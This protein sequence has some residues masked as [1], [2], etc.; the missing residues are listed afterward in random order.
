MG[1]QFFNMHASKIIFS[2][3]AAYVAAQED[4][5]SPDSPTDTA[6]TAVASSS[7]LATRLSYVTYTTTNVGT[8]SPAAS[9]PA[10]SL[11][12]C[13]HPCP[14]TRP[15]SHSRPPSSQCSPHPSSRVPLL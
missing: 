14:P 9:A 8:S 11:P 1:P 6:G 10:A 4:S 12:R 3:L 2:L 7:G 13:H 15:R 5:D